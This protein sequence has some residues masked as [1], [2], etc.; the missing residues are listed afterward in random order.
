MLLA[1]RDKILISLTDFLHGLKDEIPEVIV[2]RE[3]LV[4]SATLYSL[5]KAVACFNSSGRPVSGKSQG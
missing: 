5:E 2:W 1:S 4:V 3:R